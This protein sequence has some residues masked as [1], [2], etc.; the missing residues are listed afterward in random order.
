[1]AERKDLVAIAGLLDIQCDKPQEKGNETDTE[2]L[3]KIVSSLESLLK[4][5]QNHQ[6]SNPNN[7][8]K[9]I[10]ISS[11]NGQFPDSLAFPNSVRNSQNLTENVQLWKN[12]RKFNDLLKND[13]SC[14]RQMLINR[15]DCTVESFKWKSSEIRKQAHLE[16]AEGKKSHKDK[17]SLNDLIHEKYDQARI[18]L[19]NEP[20]ITI[21]HLLALRETECDN[22]LNSVVST[23]SVDCQVLY[24]PTKQQRQDNTGQLVNLKQVII[25]EVPDRGGRTEEMRMPSKESFS[26]QRRGR[27]GGKRY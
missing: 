19:A 24:K 8:N 12:L 6:E 15:L 1:M 26:Q 7:R 18:G 16:A 9:L 25:P 10:N 4:P 27:A 13:Y 20:Q 23:K 11:I 14:R 5:N 2:I 17:K 21:S 22:L 3:H